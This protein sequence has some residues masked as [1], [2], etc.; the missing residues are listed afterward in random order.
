MKYLVTGAAGQLG[1]CLVDR[2]RVL[3]DSEFLALNSSD[4][5]ITDRD[6]VERIIEEYQPDVVI[7]AAAY[8]AVDKAESDAELAEAVNVSGAENLA[9]AC[10][11]QDCLFFHV[12]TDYVYDGLAQI[13]YQEEDRVSPVSVYGSSKLRGE[14]AAIR[15]YPKTVIIRTAWVFSE[16]SNNFVKTMLKLAPE[17]ETLSVVGDQI[18][19]PTYAGDIADCLLNLSELFRNE[20]A[21]AGIY[22]FAGDIAVSWWS[23]A[24]EVFS[25]AVSKGVLKHPPQL[26]KISSDQFPTPVRRPAFSV[27]DC[28]KIA[29]L[30]IKPS[31]WRTALDRIIC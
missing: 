12:S 24:R 13:A 14:Q 15:A 28:S 9:L 21:Q 4:L 10:A 20:S 25:V 16:Y 7:N 22:N 11:K 5:D 6:K 23:F 8:T 17:R 31:D 2:L 19:C 30:G 29:G 1:R 26:I 3:D 27:L 18:G